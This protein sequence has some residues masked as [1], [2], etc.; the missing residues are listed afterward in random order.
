M[1]QREYAED[2]VFWSL[3]RT[4]QFS[5]RRRTFQLFLANTTA[6]SNKAYTWIDNTPSLWAEVLAVLDAAKPA[7]I[8]VNINAELAFASGLHAGELELIKKELGVNWSSRFVDVPLLAIEFVGTMPKAQLEWYR[9]L[10]GTTWAMI[11]EAFSNKVITP[12]RTSTEVRLIDSPSYKR[13]MSAVV[14]AIDGAFIDMMPKAEIA[15]DIYRVQ[16]LMSA[17]TH[18]CI[19]LCVC[20]NQLAHSFILTVR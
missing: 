2:T 7:K 15:L 8:A 18:Y 10:Q 3:K 16:G 9:K 4:A 11:S 6:S 13:A 17:Q 20:S 5:A 14:A 19:D 12:G 1:S